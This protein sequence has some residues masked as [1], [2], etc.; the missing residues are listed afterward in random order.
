MGL[1]TSLSPSM[2]SA[3]PRLFPWSPGTLGWG[4]LILKVPFDFP[5]LL[6]CSYPSNCSKLSSSILIFC[7]SFRVIWYRFLLRHI[8]L[9]ASVITKWPYTLIST[10]VSSDFW[11]L[12]GSKCFMHFL[13]QG[14]LALTTTQALKIICDLQEHVGKPIFACLHR[15]RKLWNFPSE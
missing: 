1:D 7:S 5:F 3:W 14:T 15:S 11:K 12:R 2:A 9:Y 13:L 10:W 4:S 6:H 8:L